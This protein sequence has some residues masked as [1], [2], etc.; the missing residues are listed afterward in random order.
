MDEV[1]AQNR[2]V[3]ATQLGRQVTPGVATTQ[4]VIAMSRAGVDQ[5]LILNYIHSS[6]I[7]APVTVQDVIAMHEQGVPTPIIQAMQTP[8][9]APAAPAVPAGGVVVE[10]APFGPPVYVAHPYPVCEP[11]VGFGVHVHH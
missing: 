7:A 11:H 9:A 8:A 5:Q 1:A 3:I 4:E 6:G 10:E 2:A